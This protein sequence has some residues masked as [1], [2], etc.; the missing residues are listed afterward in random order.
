MQAF[1][2][3]IETKFKNRS[4]QVVK[5]ANILGAELNEGISI[6][7]ILSL[8]FINEQ[9]L[10]LTKLKSLLSEEITVT[11][12]QLSSDPLAN[13]SYTRT[14]HGIITNYE[15]CGVYSKGIGEKAKMY[16]YSLT[17][18]PEIVKL[19]NSNGNRSFT[20]STV[21]DVI[22]SIL[23]EYSI[24]CDLDNPKLWTDKPLFN[25]LVFTQADES[26]LDFLNNLCSDFGINYT[27]EYNREKDNNKIVFSRGYLTGIGFDKTLSVQI[28][29]TKSSFFDEHTL[30]DIVSSGS[31]PYD[32]KNN[33]KLKDYT[34]AFNF[35]LNDTDSDNDRKQVIDYCR[36]SRLALIENLSDKTL[37]RANDL[38]YEPGAIL[39][40]PDYD[41]TAYYTVLRSHIKIF[42]LGEDP[43]VSEFSFMQTVSCLSKKNTDILGAVANLSRVT[44]ESK[45]SDLRLVESE[46]EIRRKNH[47]PALSSGSNT[48][49]CVG[50]VCDETGSST[51]T[52]GRSFVPAKGGDGSI[53]TKFYLQVE[54][55]DKPVI[56]HY[57]NSNGSS[58][59]YLTGFPKI[60]QKV[61]AI[62]TGGNY[63]FYAYLPISNT[64]DVIPKNFQNFMAYNHSLFGESVL[65][66]ESIYQ[67]FGNS[68]FTV[69]KFK[70]QSERIG[71][72]IL[73][74]T[75]DSFIDTCVFNF[76]DLGIY[77][78]YNTAK[79]SLQNG[80]LVT[81]SSAVNTVLSNL[82]TARA[83]YLTAKEKNDSDSLEKKRK[84]LE[85]AYNDLKT[86]SDNIIKAVND[87]GRNDYIKEYSE[88]NS[89]STPDNNNNPVDR[90]VSALNKGIISIDDKTGDVAIKSKNNIIFSGKCVSIK[91]ENITI[92]ADGDKGVKISAD[93]GISLNSNASSI[94]MNPRKIAMGVRRCY[95]SDLP[96]DSSFSI[97]DDI[98]I[99]AVNV[100]T[101]SL[102]SASMSD[103]F[104]ASIKTSSGKASVSG[105]EIAVKTLKKAEAVKNLI[106]IG[107]KATD[108]L[109]LIKDMDKSKNNTRNTDSKIGVT[110]SQK[111]INSAYSITEKILDIKE[112]INK[113]SETSA[114]VKAI[115]WMI[116]GIDLLSMC[117]ETVES[118]VVVSLNNSAAEKYK[119]R[120]QKKCYMSP[121]D[122]VKFSFFMTKTVLA[123]IQAS[124]KTI[125][126]IRGVGT[127]K[128]GITI[129]PNEAKL[130]APSINLDAVTICQD[131]SVLFGQANP[132]ANAAGQQQGQQQGG[133][134][135]QQGG[136]PQQQGGQ[137]QQQGGQPQQ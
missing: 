103:A 27:V 11:L 65:K 67:G 84:A 112:K 117:Y 62:K 25:S 19:A 80:S 106:K 30:E 87:N 75:I 85:D 5:N 128:G 42:S 92:N 41:D 130:E 93:Y 86:V 56:V 107:L 125:S 127:E 136:Q 96:Y 49:F 33:E 115:D 15:E 68:G 78:R 79:F 110:I 21:T 14:L 135:Q 52:D 54:D 132:A 44:P 137:P 7:F 113:D 111:T 32:V 20:D 131:K 74:G 13:R 104:G 6:P 81:C 18:R 94:S 116:T 121:Q 37:I 69:T 51:A 82:K 91:A 45:P 101:S 133:Q 1:K 97:G 105:L 53:P 99:S 35:L 72:Y 108:F 114:L 39:R 10:N 22:K 8:D 124:I 2:T 88:E 29:P 70:S 9:R 120:Y 129:T 64:I 73:Q 50:T 76:D 59:N 46:C 77:E 119:S 90:N 3:S 34:Y 16:R 36:K 134:P 95:I 60:G 118:I 38:N 12:R 28:N 48:S 66:N 122:W 4:L 58:G 17:I 63:L 71:S 43:A 98:K 109:N 23:S 31:L 26:D 102:L 47:K 126:Y 83:E 24:D 123:T 57:L 40:V 61:V 55:S 100:K 89:N